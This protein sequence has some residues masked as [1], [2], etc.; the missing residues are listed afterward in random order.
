M[1]KDV[2]ATLKP[3]PKCPLH[4]TMRQD[5]QVPL[6]LAS[7]RNKTSRYGYK[8][9]TVASGPVPA[10]DSDMCRGPEY[11][12]SRYMHEFVDPSKRYA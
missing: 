8:D 12:R 3:S 4:T 11:T 2:I 7:L 9:R 5:Y 1:S 6:V 10:I